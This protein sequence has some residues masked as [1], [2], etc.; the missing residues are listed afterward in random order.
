MRILDFDPASAAECELSMCHDLLAVVFA[1]DMPEDPPPSREAIVSSLVN[2][3]VSEGKVVYRAGFVGERMI[4][5]VKLSLPGPENAHIARVNVRVH[6]ADRRAGVGTELLRSVMTSVLAAGRDVVLGDA[7]RAGT[8]GDAWT[9]A[10]G[11]T[12]TMSTVM[13]VLEIAEVRRSEFD[14]QVPEGYEFVRWNGLVPERY[15]HA[16]VNARSAIADAPTARST[17]QL[18]KWTPERVRRTEREYLDRGFEQRVVAVVDSADGV[19]AGFTV[20]LR[21]PDQEETGFQGDTVVLPAHRGRGL[22]RTVKAAMM[23]WLFDD[24]VAPV[25]VYTT[26]TTENTLMLRVNIALGYR[27]VRTMNVVECPTDAL[28]RRLGIVQKA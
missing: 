20:M 25:R 8:D 3:R 10:L 27:S 7:V 26:T 2:R 13:Q 24:N 19:V 28:A 21:K 23:R 16:Y 18:G 14:V 22:G 9:R 11:F 15:L 4:G 6:P 17:Y 5:L 1:A 12:T